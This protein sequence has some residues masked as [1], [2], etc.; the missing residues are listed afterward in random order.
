MAQHDPAP[1]AHSTAGVQVSEVEA[2]QTQA[3]KNC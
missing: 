2:Q 1:G 3:R